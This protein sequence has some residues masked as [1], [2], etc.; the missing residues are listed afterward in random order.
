MAARS[1]SKARP[2]VELETKTQPLQERSRAT[3]DAILQAAGEILAESGIDNF[4]TNMVCKRAGLTPPALYRYFPNKYALLKELG[5]RLMEAQDSAVYAWVDRGGLKQGTVEAR[6]EE[7]LHIMCR[8]VAVTAEFPGSL[9]ILRAMRAVPLMQEVRLASVNRVAQFQLDT[10]RRTYPRA[11][12]EALERA[13]WLGLGVANAIIEMVLEG[14]RPD[15]DALLREGS[16]MI[17]RYY[18][19]FE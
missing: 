8:V 7:I 14:E 18:A 15:G 12:P 13:A 11:K 19:G 5:E 9:A 4:S 17:A 10:L 3:F 2:R 6:T 16:A 1:R